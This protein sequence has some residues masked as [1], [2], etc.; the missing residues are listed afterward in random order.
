MRTPVERNDPRAVHHLHENGDVVAT[1]YDLVVAVVAPAGHRHTPAT[2]AKSRAEVVEFL[3]ELWPADRRPCL[4]ALLRLFGQRGNAPV[5]W[6]DDERGAIVEPSIDEPELV[7]VAGSHRVFGRYA[8]TG[9]VVLPVRQGR[10]EDTLAERRVGL[11]VEELGR[12][13]C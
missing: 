10:S 12:S 9:L 6:I 5:R 13:S 1:L 11:A 8:I 7:V 2:A 3:C 4:C